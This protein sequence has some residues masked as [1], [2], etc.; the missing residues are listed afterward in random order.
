M[1]IYIM[2]IG[3]VAGSGIQYYIFCRFRWDYIDRYEE[4]TGESLEGFRQF[5]VQLFL[6]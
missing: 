4:R 5:M 3:F 6:I 2:K 1:L